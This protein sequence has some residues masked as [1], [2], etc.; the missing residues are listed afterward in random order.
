MDPNLP[1]PISE[2]S[3]RGVGGADLDLDRD[4]EEMISNNI[5]SS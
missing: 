5:R 4:N 3:G 2:A 1:T